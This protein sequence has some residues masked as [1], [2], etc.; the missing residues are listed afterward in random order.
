MMIFS[1]NGIDQK[2]KKNDSAAS[3][4]SESKIYPM[5]LASS[6]YKKAV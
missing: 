3:E 2:A 5:D 6:K 4:A 1:L